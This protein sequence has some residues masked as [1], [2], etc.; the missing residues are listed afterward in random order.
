[1]DYAD[2]T[3][4]GRDYVYDKNIDRTDYGYLEQQQDLI[5]ELQMEKESDSED[6]E[7]FE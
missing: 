6:E 1:M 3:K 2:L 5:E 7:E 4:L